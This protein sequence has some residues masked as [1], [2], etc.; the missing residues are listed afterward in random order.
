[1]KYKSVQ[2]INT[3]TVQMHTHKCNLENSFNEKDIT[4]LPILL[5]TYIKALASTRGSEKKK[6]IQKKSEKKSKKSCQCLYMFFMTQS[7]KSYL[8]GGGFTLIFL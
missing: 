6:K 8:R 3:N 2:N 5:E 4:E 7:K 1:M